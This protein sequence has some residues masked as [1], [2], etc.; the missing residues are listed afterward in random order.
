MLKLRCRGKSDVIVNLCH[1]LLRIADGH[2]ILEAPSIV[3]FGRSSRAFNSTC[4]CAEDSLF[5]LFAVAVPTAA[6]NHSAA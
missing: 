1:L 5:Q 6:P 4:E 2:S 3:Y